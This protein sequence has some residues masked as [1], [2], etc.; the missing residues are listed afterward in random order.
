MSPTVRNV[1]VWSG[2]LAV[3]LL[4]YWTSARPSLHFIQPL[5]FLACVAL[6]AAAITA[7]VCWEFV[8]SARRDERSPKTKTTEES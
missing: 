7:L 6:A 2:T 4:L 8:G 1:V 3:C 5:R